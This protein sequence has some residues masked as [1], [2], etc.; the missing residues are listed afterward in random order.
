MIAQEREQRIQEE[1]ARV[2]KETNT[3]LTSSGS[4]EKKPK[5]I[6]NSFF[7]A[8]QKA[9]VPKQQSTSTEELDKVEETMDA[10]HQVSI[11]IVHLK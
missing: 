5:D 6:S 11:S 10:I 1:I 2:R 9:A 3:M 4:A 8:R 7:Q